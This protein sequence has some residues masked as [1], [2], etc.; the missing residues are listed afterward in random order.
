MTEATVDADLARS[1]ARRGE[2]EANWAEGER[3][4]VRTATRARARAATRG[5]GTGTRASRRSS[6]GASTRERSRASSRR[7][8]APRGRTGSSATHLLGPAPS[9]C[10]A[11]VYYNVASRTAPKTATIQPPLLAWAWR[12]AVGDPADEPRIAPHHEWLAANRDLDGD[13]L[14]WLVQPDES[15]LDSSPKFDPVWGRRAHARPRLPL[16]VGQ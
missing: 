10:S 15:G 6:G 8:C 3:D 11:A 16:L 1:R 4:G 5:S 14:L 9:R 13:G 7:S 2:L 12:I